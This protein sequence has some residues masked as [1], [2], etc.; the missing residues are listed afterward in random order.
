[1]NKFDRGSQV[2]CCV[3]LQGHTTYSLALKIIV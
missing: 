1:M 2:I 3:I